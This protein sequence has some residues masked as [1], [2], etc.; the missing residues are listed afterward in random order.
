MNRFDYLDHHPLLHFPSSIC[1]PSWQRFSSSSSLSYPRLALFWTFFFSRLRLWKIIRMVHGFA[2]TSG[3]RSIISCPIYATHTS[4]TFPDMSV[5][6]ELVWLYSHSLLVAD[7][8]LFDFISWREGWLC[9]WCLWCLWQILSWSLILLSARRR[10]SSWQI[11]C[12]S[13]NEII[14]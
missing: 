7:K 9:L 10:N 4:R 6:L 1:L 13:W 8:N 3:C 11:I 14:L 12:L 2:G 5:F